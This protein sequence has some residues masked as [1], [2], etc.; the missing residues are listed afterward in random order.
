LS[1]WPSTWKLRFS[2][3]ASA[4]ATSASAPLPSFE[5][6]A[7]PEAKRMS[8]ARASKVDWVTQPP[9]SKRIK[10]GIDR[11]GRAFSSGKPRPDR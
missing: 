11:M 3:D 9:A 6:L 4:W 8:V 1:V 7:L 5:R 2:I 10:T